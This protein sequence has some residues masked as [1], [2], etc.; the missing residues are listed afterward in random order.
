MP[1]TSYPL[2]LLNISAANTATTSKALTT[3]S[4]TA[5][6]TTG[7]AS[8]LIKV[9]PYAMSEFLGYTHS[10]PYSSVLSGSQLASVAGASI[11]SADAMS[12]P[13]NSF[14]SAQARPGINLRIYMSYTTNPYTG[15]MHS[16]TLF[17]SKASGADNAWYDDVNNNSVH[18]GTSSPAIAYA[19]SPDFAAANEIK[20]EFN[21]SYAGPTVT[22]STA[23]TSSSI[24]VS[25]N[26][27]GTT[28]MANNTWY[29]ITNGGFSGGAT[30]QANFQ[31]AFIATGSAHFES[32]TWLK[33]WVR[34]TSL[35]KA[36]T[37]IREQDIRLYGDATITA[38]TGGFNP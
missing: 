18:M 35:N 36:A 19:F 17:A 37:V 33:I 13:E 1:L 31:K 32:T 7:T 12:I 24:S 3:L 30:V 20:F 9:S 28:T 10:T 4:T 29:T 25:G 16:A 38:S 26:G 5:I 6:A 15:T 8:Q 21:T 23:N 2:S 34:N 27:G 11:T 22:G 14:S